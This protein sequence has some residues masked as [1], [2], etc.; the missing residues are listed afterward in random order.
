MKIFLFGYGKM[1]KEIERAAKLRNHEILGIYDPYSM[2]NTFNKKAFEHSE[3]AI[4]F[5]TP[6]SVVYNILR[7]FEENKAVVVG[8]TAW[9]DEL[10][11]VKLKCKEFNGTLLYATNFSIG[12]NILNH[13][14]DYVSK[15]MNGQHGYQ[16]EINETHHTE[17]IDAPSG[18]AITLAEK[19]ISNHKHLNTWKKYHAE[20]LIDNKNNE[21]PIIYDRLDKVV[22]N[23][24]IIY[25]SDI[26]K[27]E[28]SHQAFSREGFAIG[29]L[30]A[31]E[32][33]ANK[34]GIYTINDVLISQ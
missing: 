2:Y 6:G 23:H 32:W 33:L 27:I 31:T 26:D 7:C 14:I 11:M 17:K 18:T 9:Y 5:S 15:F 20:E 13:L 19:I 24:R 25:K 4:D 16:V 34:K 10:D 3:I 1:G 21:L 8:T 12:V 22:G 28:I 30:I 29:T